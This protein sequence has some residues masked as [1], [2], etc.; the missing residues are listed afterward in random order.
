ME[1]LAAGLIMPAM[2]GYD[3]EMILIDWTADILEFPFIFAAAFPFLSE[4]TFGR[5][6]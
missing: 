1:L 5:S 3:F 4:I 2:P 6:G